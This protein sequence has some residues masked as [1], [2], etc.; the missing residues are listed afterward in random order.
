MSF[1][2]QLSEYIRIA[3]DN[4]EAFIKEFLWWSI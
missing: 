4:E 1:L 2:E 3:Y